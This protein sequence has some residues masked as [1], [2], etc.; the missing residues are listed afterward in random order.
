MRSVLTCASA[1]GVCAKSYG[2]MLSSGRPV[3][4]GEPWA[5][6]RRSPSANLVSLTLRTFHI[7]GASSRLT[8]ESD[9]GKPSST[10]ISELENV[11]VVTHDNTV[12]VSRM[13]ELV[14]YDS[15]GINKGRYQV[16]Y[17]AILHVRTKDAVKK[18]AVM[19]EW[20]PY[21]SPI[22]SNVDG[23][24]QFLDL[25]ENA[26]Y[27]VEKD[28]IT[29]VETWIIISDKRG[30]TP[31]GDQHCR[32]RRQETRSLSAAGWRDSHGSRGRLRT[33][34]VRLSQNFRAQW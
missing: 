8:V 18:G 31:P 16:Q 1:S 4:L 26:T 28:E 29:E 5:S 32:C 20:D 15:T 7:G 19:F 9:K 24:V 3:D 11:D 23:K 33:P 22:I 27:R 12:V 25:V 17:G 14:I 21:N 34:W 2:R 10:A 6:L 13:G 30:K